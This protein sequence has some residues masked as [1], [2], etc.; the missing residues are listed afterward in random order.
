M[1]DPS[2]ES[3]EAFS[4][5]FSF[6]YVFSGSLGHVLICSLAMGNVL[7]LERPLFAVCWTLDLERS[8]IQGELCFSS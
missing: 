4:H 3:Q 5:S 2:Q 1:N 7:N 6:S 8:H